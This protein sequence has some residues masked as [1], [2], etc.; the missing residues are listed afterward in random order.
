M[1]NDFGPIRWFDWDAASRRDGVHLPHVEQEG[2]IYFVT[3]RLWDSI[4]ATV[5]ERL[6][7]KRDRWLELHP[8]PHDAAAEREFRR[9]YS[10]PLERYLDSGQGECVLQSSMV[11]DRFVDTMR[12]FDGEQYQLGDYV[13][14]PNHV[15][16]LLRTRRGMTAAETCWRWKNLSARDINRMLGRRGH[17]WQSESFDHV[18]RTPQRFEQCRKYIADNPRNLPRLTYTL[19]RGCM[20]Q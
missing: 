18:V 4:P 5:L 7:E 9:V 3:F 6:K 17:V 12:R 10:L 8:L 14:M 13:I 15:H 20:L 1:A 16:L 2:A 19:G 11:R